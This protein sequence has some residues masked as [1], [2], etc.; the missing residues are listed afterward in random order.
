MSRARTRGERWFRRYE[1]NVLDQ[2]ASSAFARPWCIEDNPTYHHLIGRIEHR[3]EFGAMVTDFTQ[4]RA[5]ALHRANGGYLVVE[6]EAAHQRALVGGAQARAAQ[7]RDQD[8]GD[9]P[10]LWAGGR[11][12]LE[13]E[14]IPLDVKVVVIGDAQLYGLLSAY[15]EDFRELFKVKAEFV[16]EIKRSDG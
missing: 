2:H 3:A 15:D 6:A 7:P 1:V 5:G 4:I 8:R 11:L 12:D 16:P 10:V 14:P 9:G 13:P